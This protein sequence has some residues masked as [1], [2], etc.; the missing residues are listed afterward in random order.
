M[1]LFFHLKV[2]IKL[3]RFYEKKIQILMWVAPCLQD[4]LVEIDIFTIFSYP[5]Q[6]VSILS[7]IQV[8]YYALQEGFIVYETYIFSI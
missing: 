3:P 2:I 8:L 5:I 6:E 4:D 1:Y 7:A